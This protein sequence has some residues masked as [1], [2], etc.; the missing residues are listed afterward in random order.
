MYATPS[1]GTWPKGC[2]AAITSISADE[3]R[4]AL[5]AY[6]AHLAAIIASSDRTS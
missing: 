4:E 6:A 3:K 5:D 1:L 2:S